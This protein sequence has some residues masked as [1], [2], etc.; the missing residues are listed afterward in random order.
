ML[1]FHLCYG[2]GPLSI[3]FQTGFMAEHLIADNGLLT[4]LAMSHTQ[5][6]NAFCVDPSFG[7]GEGL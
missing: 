5:L 3:P 6:T 7:S 1:T 2:I 4:R